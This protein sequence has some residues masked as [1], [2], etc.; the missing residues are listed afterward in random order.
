MAGVNCN[1]FES[2]LMQ[3]SFRGW[4]RNNCISGHNV[5]IRCYGGCEGDLRLIKGSYYGRLEIY[6]IGSWGT[7]CDDSFRYE[8][9]LVVC[10]QLRLGTTIVQYYTAGHG[11]GTIWL[12]EVAC[13]RNENRIYNCKHRGWNVH[14]CSHSDDVGVR[15]AGSLAGTLIYSEGNVLI[16]ERLGSFYE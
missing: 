9:A 10:K 12:D 15:C 14:D 11:S 16:I 5:G 2:S 13:N 4:G 8:D 7:I 1:G 6:H 3:C